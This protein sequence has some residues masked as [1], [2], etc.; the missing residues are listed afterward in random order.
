MIILLNGVP[1]NYQ[2]EYKK[3]VDPGWL[4]MPILANTVFTETIG[5][6]LPNTAYHI[7]VK[8]TCTTTCYSLTILTTTKPTS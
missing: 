5:G 6:L 8:S 3:A 7:R 4:A 1:T 2:V